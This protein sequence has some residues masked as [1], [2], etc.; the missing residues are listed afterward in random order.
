MTLEEKRMKLEES[1]LDGDRRLRED[2]ESG[3]GQ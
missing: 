3:K 2:K 1:L